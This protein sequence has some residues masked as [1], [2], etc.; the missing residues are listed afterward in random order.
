GAGDVRNSSFYGETVIPRTYIENHY[1]KYL[2]LQ[3]FFDDVNRLPQA[4]FVLQKI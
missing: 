2:K 4:L 3:D 1:E